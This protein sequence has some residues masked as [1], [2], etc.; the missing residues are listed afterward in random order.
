MIHIKATISFEEEDKE[1]LNLIN[2]TLF[3]YN[4][5]AHMCGVDPIPSEVCDIGNGKSEL[6][7]DF[8]YNPEG[9]DNML[10]LSQQ[11]SKNFNF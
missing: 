5:M 1:S 2:E 3:S 10:K 7:F 6:R 4:I 8:D 9:A 11:L